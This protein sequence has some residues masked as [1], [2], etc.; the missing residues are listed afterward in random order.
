MNMLWRQFA[1]MLRVLLC[2][3]FGSLFGISGGLSWKVTISGVLL[4]LTLLGWQLVTIFTVQNRV[5]V[6]SFSRTSLLADPWNASKNNHRS[7]HPC[8]CKCSV[9]GWPLP[10]HCA[11][12]PSEPG[13]PHCWG[14]TVTPRHTTLGRTPLEGWSARCREYTTFSRDRH[15]CPRRDSNPQSQQANGQRPTP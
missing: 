8:S 9:S 10:P 4:L 3:P 14:F 5:T 1:D 2:V 7:S 12:A 6:R 11:T 13:P 15:Q